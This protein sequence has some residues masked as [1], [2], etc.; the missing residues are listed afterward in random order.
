MKRRYKKMKNLYD[1]VLVSHNICFFVGTIRELEV[2]RR[3]Q[4]KSLAH[5]EGALDNVELPFICKNK[6]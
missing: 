5:A 2:E 3:V 4:C 1:D 6:G